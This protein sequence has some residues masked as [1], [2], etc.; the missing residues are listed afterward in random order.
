MEKVINKQEKIK[1]S[2]LKKKNRIVLLT[3]NLRTI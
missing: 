3:K 1:K 2:Q